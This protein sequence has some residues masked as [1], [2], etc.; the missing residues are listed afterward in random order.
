MMGIWVVSLGMMADKLVTNCGKR[1]WCWEGLGA[2][3]E[4]DDRD[5]WMASPTRWTGVWVNSGSWW[6]AARPGELQIIGSQSWTR[7]SDWTKLNWT[8]GSTLRTVSISF[9]SVQYW[10]ITFSSLGRASIFDR[11]FNFNVCTGYSR[12]PVIIYF[13]L[14]QVNFPALQRLEG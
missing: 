6:W 2:G 10:H 4:G 9:L 1:L 12:L 5:G 14:F 8:V 7:L 13:H 11:G 3:G